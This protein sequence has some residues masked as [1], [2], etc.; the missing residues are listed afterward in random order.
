MD[1][2]A[3]SGYF[4]GAASK[5]LAGVD[6]MGANKSHQHELNGVGAN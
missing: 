5:V 1:Y 2:G 4:D 6:I 3:L